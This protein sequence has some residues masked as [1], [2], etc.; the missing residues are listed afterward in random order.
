M[1][2]MKTKKYIPLIVLMTALIG[3]LIFQPMLASPV[4]AQ[5]YIYTPTAE[6]NGNIYYIVKSGDTCTTISLIYN[7]SV[8]QIS[9]YNQL[10]VG[11]CDNLKIGRKLLIGI[12]PTLAITPGPSP[13]PTSS[14]PTPMPAVGQGTIC[15]YLYNDINGNAIAETGETSLAGGEISVA[16]ASGDYSKTAPTTSDDTSVC[17]ENINEGSYTISVAIPDGYNAT[18]SQNYTVKLKGG[19]TSTIDFGAQASSHLNIGGEGGSGGSSLL[20]A[21][22]GGL[23]LIAGL[24]IAFYVYMTMK[25][26]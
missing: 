13:T 23:V 2:D 16:S 20:L 3:L 12:V 24:G 1:I 21:I 6:S 7:I 4:N 15:V 26:K 18:T 17:F 19:D 8:D 9:S 10:G 25:R 11:D 14:L 22:I 5:V